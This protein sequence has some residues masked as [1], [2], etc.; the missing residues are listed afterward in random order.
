MKTLW[1]S[2]FILA[3]GA[4]AF[5][6]CEDVPEPY[7]TPGLGGNVTTD[8]S[9]PYTSKNLNDWTAVTVKG[10]AW[11]LGTNYAKASGYSGG[12]NTETEAWL[13]SPVINTTTSTGVIIDVDH[14]I[15]YVYN[16]SDIDN[17]G[18]YISK[19]YAGDVATATWTKLAYEPQA[20]TTNTWDFYAAKTVGVPEEYLNSDVVVAF[21]FTS[22]ASNSTTWELKNFS[23]KEG[24]VEGGG[25]PST[26]TGEYIY[27]ET[28]GTQSLTE[29]PYVDVYTGWL[30]DGSGA[31]NVTYSGTK[32]TVRK[33]GLANTG[34]YDGASG[35]NV[36]FF[37]TAPASFIINKIALTTEQTKLKL[38]FGA[39]YSKKDDTSGE[40]NN[41]FNTEKFN[42]SL[43]ADGTNWTPITYTK[44]N[45]DAEHPYWV[46]A[47]ADFTLTKS[48]SE[49]YIKFE[50]S[51][52]SAIRLDDIML[53]IG[54]GGQTITL[55][56]G[57]TPPVTGESTPITIAELISKMT[58]DGAVIDATANRSFEAVVQSN[59]AGGNYTTNNLCVTEEGATTAGQG[60]T[61]YGSQVD[62]KTLGL[63]QGDK[64]KITL[65]A[66][67]AKAQDY[68]G[69]YEVTGD[70]NDT[71]CTIEKIGTATVTP[72]VLTASNLSELATYQGMTVTIKN[73]QTTESSTWG[74][75]T[76]TFTTNDVPFTVYAN[77]ACTFANNTIDNTKTGSVTGIVTLYKGAPQIAPRTA[78]D[79]AAFNKPGGD[80]GDEP[81][82]N[83][84]VGVIK[85]NTITFAFADFGLEHSKPIT[86]NLIL[87]DGTTLSFAKETGTTEPA[88]FENSS[89]GNAARMYAQNSLTIAASKII[90]GIKLKL[91]KNNG[92]LANGNETMTVTPGD[93]T[94][95]DMEINISNVNSKSTQITNAHT[96]NSGGTQLRIV[97]MEITYAE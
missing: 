40:Y 69:L 96:A 12:V 20:S 67:K 37:G 8:G 36:V 24:T 15:R 1:K 54:E 72:I 73:A 38:S 82:V 46:L 47:T 78:D 19:D 14:V 16:A 90:A 3:L 88:Y 39:S 7:P 77:N 34:A 27:K 35:P 42:V 9:L 4:F 91:G 66:G 18:M 23:M 26:P 83:D 33:S 53:S 32:A 65:I 95:S 81:T 68:S 45:G 70:K 13:V 25:N 43:S 6:S 71:W 41:T 87:S 61:L 76:H 57:T 5:S 79:I 62:P 31:A 30:K 75:G 21:K 58:T 97:A 28:V 2:L 52:S 94:R 80:D 85:G 50:A 59:V 64:V 86:S 92:K 56:G 11:D 49:L 74:S 22:G 89:N 29:N 17:H 10:I 48:I 44:N 84:G 51:E 60:I 63:T 55:E 93:F